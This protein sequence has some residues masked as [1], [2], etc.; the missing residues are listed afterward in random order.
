VAFQEAEAAV[1]EGD[2]EDSGA[3]VL[4]VGAQVVRGNGIIFSFAFQLYI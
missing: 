4:A 1:V 2:L 3:E